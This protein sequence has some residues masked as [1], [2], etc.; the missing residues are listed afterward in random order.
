MTEM[1]RLKL[2]LLR[3]QA[4]VLRLMVRVN[5]IER[6]RPTGRKPDSPQS[7]VPLSNNWGEGKHGDGKQ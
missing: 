7:G 1:E 2:A 6:D 5:E 4:E 3:T